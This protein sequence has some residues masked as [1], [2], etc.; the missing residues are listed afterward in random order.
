MTIHFNSLPEFNLYLIC[1]FTW[2]TPP[3]L[4]RATTCRERELTVDHIVYMLLTAEGHGGSPRMRVHINAGA[5]SETTRTW[6]TIHTIHAPIHSN[7]A[8]MKGWLWRPNDI[9]GPGGSKV[10][11]HFLSYRWGK[12]LKKPHLRNSSLPGIE[13]G[14]AVWQARLLPSAPQRWT[15]YDLKIVKRYNNKNTNAIL[16]AR[17]H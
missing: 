16:N 9:R 1:A 13:P 8:N 2:L 10:S 4:Y 11:W 3:G 15:I 17:L 14:L 12:P 5:T 6:K 7:N